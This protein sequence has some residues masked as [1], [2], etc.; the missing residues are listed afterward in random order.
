MINPITSLGKRGLRSDSSDR[1]L[2]SCAFEA[3]ASNATDAF[4]RMSQVQPR[5]PHCGQATQTTAEASAG[6]EIG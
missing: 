5:C 4:G 2:P 1:R 3:H 6:T